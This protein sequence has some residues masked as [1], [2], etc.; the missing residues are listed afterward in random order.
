M[1]RMPVP[2]RMPDMACFEADVLRGSRNIPGNSAAQAVI[3]GT[4]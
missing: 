1:G 2:I 3:Y 4:Q